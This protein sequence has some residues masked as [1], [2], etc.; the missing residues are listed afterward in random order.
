MPGMGKY[1]AA[2]VQHVHVHVCMCRSC[3]EWCDQVG[4][5]L[6][7]IHDHDNDAWNVVGVLMVM[8]GII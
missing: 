4:S 6:L 8:V 1:H 3:D 5:V 2:V 7:Y